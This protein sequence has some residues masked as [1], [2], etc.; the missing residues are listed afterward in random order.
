M[1]RIFSLKRFGSSSSEERADSK[2]SSRKYIVR[3][4]LG[5]DGLERI[6]FDGD[7][8]RTILIKLGF[9]KPK[10]LED[11][12]WRFP[13]SVVDDDSKKKYSLELRQDH[14]FGPFGFDKD[15]AENVVSERGFN[16]NEEIGFYVHSKTGEFHFSVLTTTTAATTTTNDDDDDDD[17]K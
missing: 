14:K 3:K 10:H 16:G 6:Q 7:E 1:L 11:K 5:K 17:D 15:W 12:T 8:R 9:D 4:K 2:S 13:V